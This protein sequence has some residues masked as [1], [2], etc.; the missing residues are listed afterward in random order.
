MGGN[1]TKKQYYEEQLALINRANNIRDEDLVETPD[2]DSH[3]EIVRAIMKQQAYMAEQVKK[4]ILVS[5]LK[6][7]KEFNSI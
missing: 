7:E 3:E 6:E 4:N 2:F 5:S 1:M